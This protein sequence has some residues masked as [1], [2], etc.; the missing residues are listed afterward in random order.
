MRALGRK[1]AATLHSLLRPLNS[2]LRSYERGDMRRYNLLSEW[3]RCGAKLWALMQR[4]G[5]GVLLLAQPVLNAARLYHCSNESYDELDA[6]LALMPR[7]A[8]FATAV[9]AAY[10][11]TLA[12]A[13]TT[14]AKT[15]TTTTTSATPPPAMEML[16]DFANSGSNV[17][18]CYAAEVGR[19]R[20]ES[21]HS[22]LSPSLL[23]DANNEWV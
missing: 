18:L 20:L 2:L 17:V 13:M 3:R 21:S 7:F 15:T 8:N 4:Y 14:T 16:R 10:E 12:A 22:P 1:R 23:A 19:R 6:Q 9:S 11:A 5:T